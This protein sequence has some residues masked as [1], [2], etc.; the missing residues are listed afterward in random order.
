[1]CV[2][3]ITYTFSVLSPCLGAAEQNKKLDFAGLHIYGL[4]TDLTMFKFYSYDSSAKLF[5]SDEVI[6]VEMKRTN[7]FFGMIEGKCIFFRELP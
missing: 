3:L 7:A 2:F 1:M 5:C 4:L 6:L